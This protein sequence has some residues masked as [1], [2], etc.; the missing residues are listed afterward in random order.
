MGEVSRINLKLDRKSFQVVLGTFSFMCENDSNPPVIDFAA[1]FIS[2]QE[3]ADTVSKLESSDTGGDEVTISMNFNDWTVY[4]T[5]LLH[6]SAKIPQA[7]PDACEILDTLSHECARLD[8]AGEAPDRS[9]QV[10]SWQL[11][12]SLEK[13]S[14]AVQI[15]AQDSFNNYGANAGTIME[16]GLSFYPGAQLLRVTSQSPAVGSRYFVQHDN[17]LIPL[18]RLGDIQTFCDDRFGVSLVR[19]SIISGLPIFFR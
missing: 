3:I 2:P 13:D 9:E 7:D 4:S 12:S 17:E 8:D 5:L 10:R 15:D 18:H 11:L 6:T 14:V 16:V 1:M 19:R